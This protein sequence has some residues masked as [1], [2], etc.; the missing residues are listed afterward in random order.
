MNIDNTTGKICMDILYE[1][2]SPALTV[3]RILPAIR[4]MLAN[5]NTSSIF[6]LMP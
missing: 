1:N 2:W 6:V 5:P 4:E 3:G